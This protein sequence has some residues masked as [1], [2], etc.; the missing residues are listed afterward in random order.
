MKGEEFRVVEGEFD[1]DRL[2]QAAAV[3]KGDGDD[4]VPVHDAQGQGDGFCAEPLVFLSRGD[5]AGEAERETDE[6]ESAER[7]GEKGGNHGTRISFDHAAERR[8]ASRVAEKKAEPGLTRRTAES[9][10]EFGLEP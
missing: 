8:T 7:G 6:E 9:H 3:V 4:D 10:G 2:V 5:H 1:G